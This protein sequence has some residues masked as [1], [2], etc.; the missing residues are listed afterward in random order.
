MKWPPRSKMGCE[1]FSPFGIASL[2]YPSS[3]SVSLF[4]VREFHS[5]AVIRKRWD[6]MVF[7]H[8]LCTTCRCVLLPY[9]S[10]PFF[11]QI[12]TIYYHHHAYWAVLFILLVL[13][14]C[15]VVFIITPLYYILYVLPQQQS[16]RPV[17]LLPPRTNFKGHERDS[18][19]STIPCSNGE[20][21]EGFHCYQDESCN[22]RIRQRS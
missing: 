15:V 12:Y 3:R 20:S 21:L 14:L 10:F 11:F 19:T 9:V 17:R 5:C 1:R 22:V 16:L 7:V 18:R 8:Y 13:L 2:V 6:P 4:V